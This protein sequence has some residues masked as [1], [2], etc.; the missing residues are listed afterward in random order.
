MDRVTYHEQT[1]MENILK[2]FVLFRNFPGI[3]SVPLIQQQPQK[4]EFL[5]RTT[6]G[7]SFSSL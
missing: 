4:P 5:M 1:D 2:F 6:S 3:I 7:F